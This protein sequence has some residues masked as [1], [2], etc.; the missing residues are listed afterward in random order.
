MK[1][2][3]VLPENYIQR[4]VIDL[5]K[6]KKAFWFVNIL[7]LVIAALMVAIGVWAVPLDLEPDSDIFVLELLLP[8]IVLLAGIFA[9]IVLHEAVHGVF[10]YAFSR[11]RPRF[12]FKLV[13]AYAGSEAYFDKIRYIVI[14]LAPVVFWGMVLL[15]IDLFCKGIWFWVFYIIQVCNVGGAAGDLYVT[16]K[17]L[18]MPKDIL[19]QDTGTQMTVF[20]PV[21]EKRE[22]GS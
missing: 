13:F 19:I 7:S 5:E 18:R 20:A 2:C 16:A 8:L 10:M 14:A 9:Y 4:T 15:I 3:S 11:V 12:G 1:S 21:Q 6:D 22:E 17:I